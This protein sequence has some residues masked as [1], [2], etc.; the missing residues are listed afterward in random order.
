MAPA[1]FGKKGRDFA[2]LL[3]MRPVHAFPFVVLPL[4]LGFLSSCGASV[5]SA[6]RPADPTYAGAAGGGECK[7]LD[8]SQDALVVDLRPEQRVDLEVAMHDGVAVVAYDCKT[9]RLLKDCRVDG[10]YSF[11]GTSTK[12]QTISLDDSDEIR[13][14]LPFSGAA[15]AGKVEAEMK[16]GAKLDIALA[17]VGGTR[18][19]W[20]S[21]GKDE[22]R[23]RCEGA[24]HFVRGATLGA[25][26]META[27][28]ADVRAAVEI[29][30]SRTSGVSASERKVMNRDGDLAACK[31]ATSESTSAPPRCNA[32][33]RLELL[34]VGAPAPR[35]GIASDVSCPRGLVLTKGKCTTPSAL[36]PHRCRGGDLLDCTTQCNK[37]D[38]AS[39]TSLGLMFFEGRGAEQDDTKA[40]KYFRQGCDQKDSSGCVN[41]AVLHDK[42]RGGLPESPEKAVALTRSACEDGNANGC[43]NLGPAA[44]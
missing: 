37:G 35:E 15:L 42:G 23:G 14:N 26:A 5:A 19:N 21:I 41:L 43:A 36:L 34:A 40:A 7:P 20:V 25:F 3:S 1:L 17:M 31:S 30:G 13:A 8:L 18:T 39:C 6:L 38:P 27:A 24:T 2:Y 29:F 33:L 10:V 12:E 11:V 9:I 4:F 44:K 28:K 16:R 22:L 32:L